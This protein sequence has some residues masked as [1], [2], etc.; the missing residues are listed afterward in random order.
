MEGV[1]EPMMVLATV[2]MVLKN[3]GGSITYV[4]PSMSS[5]SVGAVWSSNP[6]ATYNHAIQ[7]FPK[8]KIWVQFRSV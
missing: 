1:L 8:S 3:I 7:Y 2:T 5:L 4:V 6:L